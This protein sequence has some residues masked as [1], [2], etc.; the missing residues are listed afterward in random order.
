MYECH[1]G[2]A[3]EEKRVGTY[4]EFTTNVLPR[5]L[6]L[7]ECTIN[8]L[9]KVIHLTGNFSWIPIGVLALSHEYVEIN[10]L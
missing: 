5:I 10:Y 4:K 8:V 6:K 2:I 1:V 9:E 3:T 7:G